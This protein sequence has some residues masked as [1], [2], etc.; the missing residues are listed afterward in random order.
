MLFPFKECS[1]L[2]LN[3]AIP[4]C[5][6]LQ[7]C[8]KPVKHYYLATDEEVKAAVEKVANQGKATTT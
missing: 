2:F 8:L 5:Y 3:L 6:E 1:F 7:E 4:L